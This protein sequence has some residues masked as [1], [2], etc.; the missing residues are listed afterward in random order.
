VIAEFN[1]LSQ[2]AIVVMGLKVF[3]KNLR[4]SPVRTLGR[5]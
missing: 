4:E 5:F 2:T 1:K 3:V